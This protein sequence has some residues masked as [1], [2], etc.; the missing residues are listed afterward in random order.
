[1]NG[2]YLLT[3]GNIGDREDNLK[4]AKN[5]ISHN[6]GNLVQESAIYETEAWGM[7]NQ[8]LFLNQALKIETV[9]DAAQL[10][11]CILGIEES[12]G[13]TRENKYGP[14]TIDIDILL[15]N[16][17]VLSEPGLTIPHPQLHNRR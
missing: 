3:G 12:M 8:P 13:R 9:L 10:L 14:R 11:Q 2:V 15:F 16:G 6:C 5:K 7:Q 1:M 4:Q 17:E